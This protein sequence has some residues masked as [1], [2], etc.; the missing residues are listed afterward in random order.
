MAEALP[1]AIHIRVDELR[2]VREAMRDLGSLLDEL[3]DG[4]VQ[5]LVLT[6]RNKLRGVVV[7]VERWSEAE[8][9]LGRLG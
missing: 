6:Q 2:T 3:D 7:S 8:Q 1:P 9:A 4:E 5:K